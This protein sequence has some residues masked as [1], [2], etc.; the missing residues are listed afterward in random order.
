MWTGWVLVW[1]GAG[2][3]K[4]GWATQ[5]PLLSIQFNLFITTQHTKIRLQRIKHYNIWLY[6]GV[7]WNTTFRALTP[8]FTNKKVK[9]SETKKNKK[10]ECTVNFWNNLRAIQNIYPGTP[11]CNKK[12]SW[13]K[14]TK[15]KPNKKKTLLWV[16]ENNFIFLSKMFKVLGKWSKWSRWMNSSHGCIYS[17]NNQCKNI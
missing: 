12:L 2:D 5:A 7:R 8:L 6:N 10:M 4:W 3:N 1:M 9:V 11:K 16:I 13:R 15:F 14:I 17:I